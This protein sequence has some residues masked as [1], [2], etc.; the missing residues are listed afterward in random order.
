M[1][2]IS[3]AATPVVVAVPTALALTL[4]LACSP[5]GLRHEGTNS[6][7]PAPLDDAV[8]LHDGPLDI[9]FSNARVVDP[10]TDLDAVRNLGVRGA[11]IIAITTDSLTDFLSADGVEVDATGLVL[12]PGF[13]DLHAHGQGA[14]SH[15]YQA[16]DG[17]TTALEL[18]WGSPDVATFLNARQGKSLI[19]FGT[20]VSHGALRALELVPA[21][22]R[23]ALR[24][25]FA[26][27]AAADEPLREGQAI[28]STT[29]HSS[30][31]KGSYSKMAAEL[32]K[33]LKQ[34]GLGIGLPHQ[35]YP[36]ATREEVFEVFRVAAN[37]QAPIYTHVRSMTLD[38][39]QEVIANAAGT[40]APLHIVHVNS[41]S[42]GN[43]DLVLSLIQG[44]K[45]R[46][47]DVTT[48]A[49]PYTAGSTGI[50]SSIFEDGWQER[51]GI[52]YG[53]IQ[54]EAT[55]ER[56]TEETFDRYRRAGGVVILHVMQ[57]AWVDQ[58]I[59][60]DWVIVASDGMPYAP[61]AHPRSAGTFS[62]VLGR[63]VRQRGLLELTTAI[64]KMTLLPAQRLEVIAPRMA[65]KGRVQAGADA[66]LV[67]FD[68]DTVI[69]T[70]T[71]E[72]DL[73]FST[74]IRHVLVNGVFVVRDGETVTDV[75]PGIAIKGHVPDGPSG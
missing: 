63:Y 47:V 72:D 6:T 57:E 39:M 25:E 62:R 52:S 73:S 64:K 44:A 68:P 19:H 36:G 40:G 69:D 74:G 32:E 14:T 53:D 17:V 22:D 45:A 29:F 56:L 11:K 66:D 46:G 30:L 65:K 18:E 28:V 15:E 9:V 51:L 10:E 24:L 1:R 20:S 55:G 7:N 23:E 13:I 16:R 5:S 50:Q 37:H 60:N 48:E 3:S 70:A 31:I 54:W 33:G 75:F 38:A 42:L 49:Y 61:G 26:Q 34:G 71:F 12:A 8:S 41:M 43:I 58:A 21:E 67:L 2:R 4:L 35:Y 59:A 27:S